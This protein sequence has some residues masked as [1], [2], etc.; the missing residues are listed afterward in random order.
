MTAGPPLWASPHPT[1][2]SCRALGLALLFPFTPHPTGAPVVCGGLPWAL[3]LVRPITQGCTRLA[4]PSSPRPRLVSVWTARG[5]DPAPTEFGTLSLPHQ[6]PSLWGWG[7]RE[8]LSQHVHQGSV[9]LSPRTAIPET[10]DHLIQDAFS[11]KRHL[12]PS[13]QGLPHPGQGSIPPG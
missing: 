11:P 13:I 4:V 3:S 7:Q 9:L 10:W 12:I 2:G 1:P 5:W 8:R 6:F